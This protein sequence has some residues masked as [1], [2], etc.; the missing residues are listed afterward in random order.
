MAES[1]T[2]ISKLC[3]QS[4]SSSKLIS[5]AQS[6]PSTKLNFYLLYV[7]VFI[8]F[9]GPV[10]FVVLW[11]IK[12]SGDPAAIHPFLVEISKDKQKSAD[13]S[14]DTGAAALHLAIRCGS[15]QLIQSLV[16]WPP[17][18]GS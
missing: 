7:A 3:G 17:D 12:C 9:I 13:G 14:V 15:G 16:Q 4:I 2:D 11:L 10:P 5:Y 8:L 6:N 1:S 18:P